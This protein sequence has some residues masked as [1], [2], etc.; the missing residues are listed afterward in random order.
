MKIIDFH[1]KVTGDLEIVHVEE[2]EIIVL[3]KLTKQA[4]SISTEC[5][6]ENTWEN[7]EPIFLGEREPEALYHMSRVV[8]YFSR[9]DNWNKSKIGELKDRQKGSYEIGS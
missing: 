9:I 4:C 5:I 7:L 8:G 6:K 3:N 2:G 1:N